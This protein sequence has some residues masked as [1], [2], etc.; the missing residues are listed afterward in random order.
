MKLS[1]LFSANAIIAILFGLAF[2][3]I[4]ATALSWYGVTLI[5]AGLFISRLLGICYIGFAIISWQVRGSAASKDLKAILLA[6]FVGD[7]LG[8]LVS[9]YYQLQGIANSLG[10]LTVAIYLVLGVGFGYFYF[11][12]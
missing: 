10:W 4:P 6:F 2:A 5:D 9:L 1:T 3:V 8:F 11:K 12:K 7:I